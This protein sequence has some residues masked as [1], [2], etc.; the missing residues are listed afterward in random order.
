[1]CAQLETGRPGRHIMVSE[2]GNVIKHQHGGSMVIVLN[3][4]VAAADLAVD[5]V[6][7]PENNSS[8][9]CV[10]GPFERVAVRASQRVYRRTYWTRR[11]QR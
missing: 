1:V 7:G 8:V 6:T 10:F 3:V 2:V 4:G 9:A 5:V 11:V